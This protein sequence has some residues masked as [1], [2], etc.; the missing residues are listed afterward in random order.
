MSLHASQSVS[1]SDILISDLLNVFNIT[2]IVE[3]IENKMRN[4]ARQCLG[5]RYIE[6]QFLSICVMYGL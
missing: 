4:F 2:P 1:K 5:S 6:L 3:L